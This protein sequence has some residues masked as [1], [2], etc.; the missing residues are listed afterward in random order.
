MKP[1]IRHPAFPCLTIVIV[2]FVLVIGC[3]DK[4][5]KKSRH[6]ERAR[7][8]IGKN[9]FEKG[10]VELEN[11]VRLDPQNDTAY[12][13]LG[14]AYLKLKRGKKAFHSFDRAVAI[15]PDNLNAQLK[16][17]RIFLLRGKTKE[18]RKKAEFVL[19][20]SPDNIDALTLLSGAQVREKDIDSAIRTLK[21]AVSINPDYFM[22]HLDLARLFV[23]KRDLDQAEQAYLKAIS[24]DHKSRVPYIELARI[25]G[26]K[27]EWEKTESTLKDM[28]HG[29]GSTYQNFFTLAGFYESTGK[30][31]QA[32][33]TYLK[34]VTYAP[35]GEGAPLMNLGGYYARRNSYKKALEAMQKAA[36]IAKDD[37]NIL[38]SIAQLHFD[39]KKIE[40]A[41]ST[42]DKVLEKKQEHLGANL[43]KGRLYVLKRDFDEALERFDLV[44][45]E[46]PYDAMGYYFRALCRVGKGERN[47]AEQE[48]LKSVELNP[49]LV[50]AR[51]IL[52]EFYLR[53]RKRD[54]ARQQI[55]AVFALAPRHI[56][57][58]MLQGDL[59][60][61]EGDM[62]GA[63][64]VFKQVVE[65][66]PNMLP[67]YLALARI[68]VQENRLEEAISQY[69]AVL[70]KNTKHFA[71]YMALGAIYDQQGNGE[72]AEFYYRKA[73]EIKRDFGPAANNLAW[74]MVERG[75]D[76]DEALEYARLAR[77]Q[78]PK[79][80]E[81]MDT[82]GRIYYLKGSYVNAIAEF[83]RSLEIGPDNPAINY[84]LGLAYYKN[85]QPDSAREFLEKALS[86]D[87][88]FK[89]AEEA[90]SILKDIVKRK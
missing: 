72:K 76:I 44:V 39:F 61:L 42:V 43:L 88:N 4:E 77:E 5:D 33:K 13:E 26:K 45:R 67:P 74:N 50:D 19:K 84:H 40:D 58:L 70:K 68:Y 30:L 79:S 21:K 22:I 80:P 60:I 51:L 7:E 17:G 27:G 37:L 10:A 28:I 35:E 83:Q 55:E 75:G 6:L 59:K 62:K 1:H 65:L 63:E 34:A 29:S 24:L 2:L 32:E 31:D 66:N 69:E 14:E 38:A 71:G 15:N 8:Y 9:E 11:L 41:E 18:A 46:R 53:D 25:Y 85:N 90:R 3:A 73:L 64:A 57:A 54:L 16:M 47:L 12:Y 89:G 48:L 78:M 86:L 49:H 20:K 82:L 87:Q 23:I 52:A 36:A 56:K 81:V